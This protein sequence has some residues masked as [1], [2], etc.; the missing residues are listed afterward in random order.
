MLEVRPRGIKVTTIA[1][2]SVDTAFAGAPR[3]ADTSWMLTPEDV[4]QTVIDL[5][6]MRDGAHSSRVEMRPAGPQKR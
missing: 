5:L 2:G 3:P 1:P 6:R 4:A